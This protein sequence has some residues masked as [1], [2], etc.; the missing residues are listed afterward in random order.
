M[1]DV[2]VNFQNPADRGNYMA[3]IYVY[4]ANI[5]IFLH[6]NAAKTVAGGGGWGIFVVVLSLFVFFPRMGAATPLRRGAANRR[7]RSSRP[8]L[9]L[10]HISGDRLRS[11]LASTSGPSS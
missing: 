5:I 4:E 2:S 1:P 8:R 3:I 7:F 6:P 10:G 11:A 9:Y